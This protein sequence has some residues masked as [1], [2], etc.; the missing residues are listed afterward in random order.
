MGEFDYHSLSA[1]IA[2]GGVGARCGGEI[3]KQFQELDGIPVILRTIR[4]FVQHPECSAIAVVV[5]ADWTDWMR[6]QVRAMEWRDKVRV[7][8]GGA[9]R[10]DSVFAGLKALKETD[11]VV[12]HDAARPFLTS[13]MITES[14]KRAWEYGGATTAV[15]VTDTLKRENEGVISGTV[16]RKGLYRVQTPQGFR[17]KIIMKAYKISRKIGFSGT[18]DC[19]LLERFTGIKV[20]LVKGSNLNIKITTPEDFDIAEA[21]IRMNGRTNENR[22]MI[23]PGN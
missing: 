5:P 22:E 10:G 23:N 7:V 17:F 21:I 3:P 8:K 12:I 16:R 20:K 15:P 2:G 6:K 14:A 11:V 19:V 9:E 1:V 18:D 13:E 4:K